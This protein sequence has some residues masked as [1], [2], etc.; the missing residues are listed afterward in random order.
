MQRRFT[1]STLLALFALVVGLGAILVGG[2]AVAPAAEAAVPATGET[3]DVPAVA[4]YDVD[5]GTLQEPFFLDDKL[6]LAE[7]V[8]YRIEKPGA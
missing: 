6:K 1:P 3:V 2:P 7:T 8:G 4:I 5:S